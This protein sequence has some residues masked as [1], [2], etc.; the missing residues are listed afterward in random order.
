V[1]QGICPGRSNPIIQ[2]RTPFQRRAR[3]VIKLEP[4]GATANLHALRQDR[5]HPQ[6]NQQCTNLLDRKADLAGGFRGVRQAETNSGPRLP[7]Q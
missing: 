3:V 5:V 4:A 2:R 7:A 1:A 6:P